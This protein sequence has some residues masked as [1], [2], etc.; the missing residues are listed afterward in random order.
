MARKKNIRTLYTA[1]AVLAVLLV[2]IGGIALAKHGSQKKADPYKTPETSSSSTQTPADQSSS[3]TTPQP[4]A[5]ADSPETAP[6]AGG[7]DNSAQPLDPR[8]VATID[9]TPL[10]I[11]VSYV[12]GVGAFQY[13]VARTTNGTRYVEFSNPDLAG[14]KCTND[15]GAFASILVN[16]GENDKTT[17]ADTVEADGVTYGLSLEPL[18]CTGQPETVQS[19]QESFSKAFSLLTTDK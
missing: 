5:N 16:P 4:G 17:L 10:G 12:K 2:V 18:T 11:T 14:T 9:I 19:Y 1:L 15:R 3:G 13:Q 6:K 8:M 7:S